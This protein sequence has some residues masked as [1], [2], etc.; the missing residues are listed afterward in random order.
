M[1]NTKY[2][3]QNYVTEDREHTV[4][5]QTPAVVAAASSP[6]TRAPVDRAPAA[7]GGLP[8][9]R[10]PP[11]LGVERGLFAVAGE[12]AVVPGQGFE[13]LKGA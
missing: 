2:K 9:K 11:P 5:A 1:Q 6:C 12:D 8:Q 3:I 13:G 4:G 7:A 10:V